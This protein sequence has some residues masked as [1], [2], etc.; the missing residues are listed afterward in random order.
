MEE[1]PDFIETTGYGEVDGLCGV[2]CRHSFSPFYNILEGVTIFNYA[3]GRR[4]KVEAALLMN[5]RTGV[6]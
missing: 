3:S 2:N 4:I 5:I 1:Y 6:A